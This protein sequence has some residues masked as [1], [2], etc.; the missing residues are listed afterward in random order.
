MDLATIL[1]LLEIEQPARYCVTKY[2][3]GMIAFTNGFLAMRPNGDQGM[4]SMSGH[5]PDVPPPTEAR[6]EASSAA[7]LR[8]TSSPVAPA[9]STTPDATGLLTAFQRRWR[10]ALGLGVLA[11]VIAAG[12][13]WHL[14]PPN[15]YTAESLLLV[16]PAQPTV[17]AKTKEYRSDPESDQR[18]QLAL[19]KSLVLSKV[20]LQPEVAELNVIKRQNDPVEWLEQLIK[21]EFKGKI[22]SISLTGDNAAEVTS[23]VKAVTHTYL[24]EVA[25]KET[26]ERLDRNASLEAH[27]D[28]LNK[29]LE[30]KR[31]L[32]RGL[33]TAVGSKD[34]QNLS[35][36]QRLAVSRQSIAEE[37]L[38][39]TQSDLKRAMAELKVLQKRAETDQAESAEPATPVQSTDVEEAILNDPVVKQYLEEEQRIGAVL[40]NVK[41][42]VRNGERSLQ[43]ESAAGIGKA[44]KGEQ[45][46]Y[47]ALKIETTG[48]DKRLRRSSPEGRIE[49]R[50]T[51]GSDRSHG[52]LGE[53]PSGG[54][55]QVQR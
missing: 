40:A 52:R 48:C 18:T 9:L 54:G 51:P 2:F 29:Q 34:K 19:V 3:P 22:L 14:L 30:S 31:K 8:G 38:L 35:M 33:S 50:I 36:Q 27:Y 23:L 11:A 46:V 41:R 44:P 20:V 25:N 26:L 6:I 21:A 39:R 7:G 15:K 5:T 12:M 47:R 55:R 24:D 28:R 49:P 13:V 37:E 42:V 45:G 4:K 32:L 1:V 10:L 17:I 16:E 53:G 43:N